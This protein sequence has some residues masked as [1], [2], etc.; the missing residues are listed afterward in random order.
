MKL[1]STITFGIKPTTY[2]ISELSD[3]IILLI[4]ALVIYL[5]YPQ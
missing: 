3:K 4:A 2:L 5:K 1:Q